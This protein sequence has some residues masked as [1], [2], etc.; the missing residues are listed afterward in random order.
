MS[1]FLERRGSRKD[2]GVPTARFQPSAIP[3]MI[4]AEPPA[5]PGAKQKKD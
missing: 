3:I 4:G 2:Q 5:K 1:C